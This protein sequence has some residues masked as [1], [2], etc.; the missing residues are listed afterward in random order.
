MILLS[1]L[2]FVATALVA[3]VSR[4]GPNVLFF[5]R[6]NGLA[7]PS[8]LDFDIRSCSG[9]Y[10]DVGSNIGVQ[11]RKLY[12]PD[13]FPNAP[14][15]E[16]FDRIFGPPPRRSVCAIGF[17]P[18]RKHSEHLLS[19]QDNLRCRGFH[20]KFFTETAVTVKEETLNFYEDDKAPDEVHEWGASLINWQNSSNASTFEVHGLD[21]SKF[22]KEQ[23]FYPFQQ[24]GRDLPPILMKIDIEGA[25]FDVLPY[26][27]SSGSLC[28]IDAAFIEWHEQIRSKSNTTFLNT[29]AITQFL[30]GIKVVCKTNL[31][32]LDDE[33]YGQGK[34]TIPFPMC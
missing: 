9:I 10:L 6:Q 3:V 25:E 30:R 17:E 19:I 33:S 34:T 21:F 2:A 24:K 7:F 20:M 15:L 1:A 8:Q 16:I 13:L 22:L 11:I 23:I 5:Q 29:T 14:V 28:E 26:L 32:E 27:I 18:N 12:D 31:I 4:S